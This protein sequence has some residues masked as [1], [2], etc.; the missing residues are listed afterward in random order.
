MAPPRIIVPGSTVAF[1]RRATFRKA[2]LGDWD[3]RVSEAW[4]YALADAQREHGVA[5]HHGV[6]CVNHHHVEV[7]AG[8]A[9]LPEF[10]H[11]FHRDVSCALSALMAQE[12]YD[13]PGQLFDDRPTHVMQL[14]DEPAQMR[15]LL[16]SHLNPVAAGLV[17]RP[18]Q[19]PGRVLSFRDWLGDGVVVKRPA[20]YFGKD[21]P[22]ELR[23]V[24]TPPLRLLAAFGGDMAKLVYHLGRLVDEGVRAH[25][26][27]RRGPPLGADAL[28]RM[29]PWAEPR[30]LGAPGGQR[31]PS[32]K[33]GVL[34]PGGAEAR[35]RCGA[36]V[37]AFR[38]QYRRV[39]EC[40]LRG[41]D[42][43]YP[44]GTYGPRVYQAA[45]VE[46]EPWPDALLTLPG[47][48]CLAEALGECGEHE[49]ASRRRAL[50]DEVRTAQAEDV[51]AAQVDESI[52]FRWDRASRVELGE[53]SEPQTLHRRERSAPAHA[54][55]QHPRR[56]IIER[57]DGDG[58]GD[59]DTGPPR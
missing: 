45:P 15:H 31:V 12:R 10:L 41:E 23:L 20:F 56:L 54:V 28:V 24:L 7:T 36:E 8:E 43:A 44:H 59:G 21:R 39:R 16:Y 46:P 33:I 42:V 26:V 17:K 1:A 18:E 34:G 6:R 11:R 19:M 14:V 49:M 50:L 55:R 35:A 58:R 3:P 2:F 38:E 53:R 13:T 25:R 51:A 30:T 22:E 48:R 9:N 29:H 5:V 4:L 52:E 57:D 47:P 37:R 27:G 32:F 40:R